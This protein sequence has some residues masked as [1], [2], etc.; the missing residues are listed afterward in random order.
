[1]FENATKEDLVTVLA[2]MGETVDADLGIMELKQ[3][4]MLNKAYLEDEEFVRHV[5]ATTIEDR[6]EKEEDRRKEEK[7]KEER[8]RNEEEYKEERK[9]KE[10]EFKK[11][12]EERRLERILEL[13]LARIEAA[14]WKAEKEAIIREARHK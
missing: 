10:E 9:K 14:R 4:L 12:A 1:M 3:K 8:R 13:E 7:Y 11:K 6:M 2:E 5:L